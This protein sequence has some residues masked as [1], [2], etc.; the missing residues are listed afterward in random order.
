MRGRKHTFRPA[1]EQ[2]ERRDVPST[3]DT[4]AVIQALLAQRANLL[5]SALA[6]RGRLPRYTFNQGVSVLQNRLQVLGMMVQQPYQDASDAVSVDQLRQQINMAQAILRNGALSPP[7]VTSAMLKR[8]NEL[9]TQLLDGI[10]TPDGR[11]IFGLTV[12]KLQILTLYLNLT[13]GTAGPQGP[14]GPRGL[15]GATGPQGPQGVT[16]PQGPQGDIGPQGPQGDIGPQ[17]AQGP[18]GD[19]GGPQGPQGDTGPQ[20]PQGDA[21]PQ[22]PQGDTG[23]QGPQGDTGPQG[24]QGDA[25]PQGP[26]GATG[27][28]FVYSTV[29]SGDTFTPTDPLNIVTLGTNPSGAAAITLDTTGVPNNTTVYIVTA[30]PDGVD[31]SVTGG[32]TINGGAGPEGFAGRHSLLF[33]FDSAGNDWVGG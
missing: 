1:V 14:I 13:T 12:S 11:R 16:G 15:T 6:L 25:G 29:A 19:P 18:Q 23:P 26:Q 2:L 22:G 32:G 24:P 21:G 3:L 4:S 20:G 31:V 7:Q 30:D 17:G 28:T 5:Q 8:L 27:P 33:V 9:Q 10:N